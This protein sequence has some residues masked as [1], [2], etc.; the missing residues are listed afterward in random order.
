MLVMTS[1]EEDEEELR[2]SN[3]SSPNGGSLAGSGVIQA[4]RFHYDSDD[5]TK[6]AVPNKR[7][8]RSHVTGKTLLNHK[9]H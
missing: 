1:H 3:D 6:Y 4:S 2:G 7:H 8:Q 9:K 5:N